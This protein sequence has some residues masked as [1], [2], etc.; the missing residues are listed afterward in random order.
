M[1]DRL[2][3]LQVF[4]AVVRRGTF[5]GAAGELGLSRAMATKHVRAL[6]NHLGVRLFNRTTRVTRLTEAGAR[7]H[8]QV[9]DLVTRLAL[10]E[11]SLV[12]DTAGVRGV[13]TV[14]APPLFGAL[15]LAPVVAGF[16]QAFPAV[17]VRLVLTDRHVDLVD[18]GI[19]VAVS[20]RELGDS[21]AIARRLTAVRMTV[22]ASPA[23]LACRGHPA[24][25]R[26]L[27]GHNCL[28]FAEHPHH[29]QGEWRFAE[30]GAA[31]DVKV[32]GDFVSNAGD[33]LRIVAVEGRGL[34]RLPHYIVAEALAAGR[35]ATVLEAYEPPLRPVHALYAHREHQPGKLRSFLDYASA[36]FGRV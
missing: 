30:D 4:L 28:L 21:S 31:L 12:D 6:E 24:H 5:A 33:A 13:L 32:S 11:Q 22:C 8:E 25:P 26:D 7:Y 1:L 34:V 16:M 14:A 23:Y 9:A 29:L 20:V 17:Q 10:V 35:L 18:E 36:A 27:A 3:S 19:D 2:T 15:H